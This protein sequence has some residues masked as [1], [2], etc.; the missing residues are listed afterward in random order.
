[1]RFIDK[2]LSKLTPAMC[3]AEE[4]RAKAAHAAYGNT[5][6]ATKRFL[7]AKADLEDCYGDADSG[8]T[9]EETSNES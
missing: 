6:R 9:S 1:M 5:I 7:E 8:T 2:P 3:D 4:A